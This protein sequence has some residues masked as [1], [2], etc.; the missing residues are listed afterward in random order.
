MNEKTREAINE[1]CA[2]AETINDQE[3]ILAV[4]AEYYDEFGYIPEC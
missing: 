1:L 3:L 4:L 2:E